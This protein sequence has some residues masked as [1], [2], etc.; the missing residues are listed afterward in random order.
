M[1][2]PTGSA[3]PDYYGGLRPGNNDTRIP[4]WRCAPIPG[5]WSGTSRRFITIFGVR[6]SPSQPTL[7][8]IR[9]NGVSIPAVAVG[10]KTGHLFLLHRE[11]GKPLSGGGARSA[12]KRCA[13]RTCILP[14]PFPTMPKALVPQRLTV[15]DAWGATETDRKFCREQIG[16]LRS[17]GIFTP[18]SVQGSLVFPGHVGGMAWGGAAFDAPHGLLIIPTN[19]LAAVVH[20]IPRDKIEKRRNCSLPANTPGRKGNTLFHAP[21]F[22]AQPRQNPLQCT[23]VGRY[24]RHRYPNRSRSVGIATRLHRLAHRQSG[25][26]KVGLHDWEGRL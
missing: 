18:P 14:Q 12:K 5:S 15:D 8:T 21:R 24:H 7:L 17:E 2:V 9:K 19:R 22:P 1:F 25:G 10:S 6:T 23:A 20:L 26:S 13:G 4:L 3:S 11:T 16:A